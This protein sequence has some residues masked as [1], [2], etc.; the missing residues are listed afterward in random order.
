[1][2]RRPSGGVTLLNNA[3]GG[4]KAQRTSKTSQK[5]VVLPSEPQTKPILGELVD[6][7]SETL[8]TTKG[9]QEYKSEGERMTKS[10]RERAGFKRLTAYCVSE[11][12]RM[13]LLAAF[14][15]REHNVAPRVY[16]EALY[17]MYH[18]PLLPGYD[19]SVNV[20]SSVASKSP[21]GKSFLRRLSEA[22]ENGYE[23]T[24]FISEDGED[25]F[26]TDGFI[27]SSSPFETRTS[28]EPGEQQQP[29]RR[30]RAKSVTD[31]KI[32]E[33]IFFSYGVIVFFGLR[34]PQERAIIEDINTAGILTRKFGED[35]WEVEECHFVYDPN[36]AYQRI[37]NDLF[38]FK[39][40]SHLLKLSIAHAL[41][42]STLL[43][44][45][46]SKAQG[47]LSDPQTTKIPRMLASTGELKL[48][49]RDALRLT[50][51]LFQL[52]RD[53]NLVSNVLDVP[54]LFWSEASLKDLY[55]AVREYMEIGPRVHVL[56][57]KLAVANDLLDLIHGH[58]NNS[59]MERITWIII[60]L[61]VV[62]CLVEFG[63]VLARLIV[64]STEKGKDANLPPVDLP[65]SRDTAMA[66]LERIMQGSKL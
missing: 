44:R 3:D 24:Y 28:N 29:R 42:Q 62:A 33:V 58:L 57:E 46:E 54:E 34:E 40:S 51:R 31:E 14:L 32:A 12:L 61:I 11:S 64:N 26:S 53:V 8:V 39:S 37:Y 41:A 25:S 52:R 6:E 38:T 66:V 45:Y 4:I 1:M 15:K 16:D 55:D 17:V 2:V 35:A 49:R 18:L 5:L 43:A 63:E 22:E 20:R 19:P 27:V 65:I 13:K 48:R 47:V 10:E 60:W 21:N 30:T 7:A 36:T 23:G 9:T 59:A 50:G 56:N